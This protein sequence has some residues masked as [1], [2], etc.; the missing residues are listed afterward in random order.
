M[1][2][3]ANT[4]TVLASAVTNSSTFT[5]SYPTGT[6]QASLI[7]STTGKMVVNGDLVW[8][9]DAS[10]GFTLTFG[11]PNITV[12][13]TT[14]A[15]LAAGSTILLSFGHTDKLG[16]YNPVKPVN[17]PVALTMTV[18]TA[19]DTIADVGASFSQTTLNNN[20]RSLGTK[21]NAIITALQAAGIMVD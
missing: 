6:T 20:T 9:Q 11:S 1:S 19:S 14:G 12:T 21:I 8:T 13:N 4:S 17:A 15:T 2:A 10:P 7:G 3:I 16:K 5:V 18:G